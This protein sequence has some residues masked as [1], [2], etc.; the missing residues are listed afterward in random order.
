MHFGG[1]GEHHALAFHVDE[2]AGHVIQT[3][4][5]VLRR[6]DDRITVGGRQDV[7][8]R[9]HQRAR[10]ELRFERQ[11]HVHG[12]LVAVEVGV[13]R[14]AD[15]RM[16]LDGL[17]FDQHRLERL[18]AETMQRRRTV[19]QHG[20]LADDFL[21]DVPHF[22][23]FAFD[24]LLRRL[25]RRGEATA[26]Q[27]GEDE[28]L[29]QFQRHLL[30]QTALVQ[31]QRRTDHDHRT[32][33]VIDALA[34]QVL[35]ETALLAL[36]HVGERL[37][38]TLVGARD[39]AAATAVVHQRIDSFL[40]HAL[41]VAHDDVGRIEFEQALQA[42]VA[43]DDAAIQVVQIRRRETS[44]FQRDER[45][46]IRRQHRQHGHD[47]EFRTVAGFDERFDELDALGQALQ[48]RLGIRR[49]DFFAQTDQFGVQI[50]RLE[51]FVDG[52]G[53]H[54]GIEFVAV[55]FDGLQI[56]FFVEQLAARERGQARIDDDIR[57]EIQDAF[58]V[59]QR[60]V[61]H[62]TDA[63]RQRFQEPDVRGRRGQFDVAHALAA[64]LGQRDFGAAL[65]ADD[66]AM[67]HALVLAAEAFVVLDR[68]EDGRAEQAVT[69]R[70]E[71][72]VVDGF[73]LLHFA[74]R[75]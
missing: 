46:Q 35:T 26:L 19:E 30:R 65:F 51:Q 8:R 6:H 56:L 21:E 20:M 42:V 68:P 36:D 14:G 12:H 4:H 54:A 63:R 25:D 74:E 29:E 60:H 48:L 23:A 22:R 2:F 55:F 49:R 69:L 3:E 33:G 61:E 24:F 9:H 59:T 27:L 38:R 50:D 73:G 53:T 28:G 41:F 11:R 39:G 57:F 7:V 66:A 43:V 67:L 44:A 34:E 70:F 71:R 40:Q 10:F 16:Q 58:D 47:H 17:A 52:F 18:D 13:E 72:A 15:Q 32:A 64:H 5:D 45:T 37:Q 62:Q 75:P 1:V 31:L